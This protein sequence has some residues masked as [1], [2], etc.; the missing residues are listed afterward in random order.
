M[1]KLLRN[2]LL[3]SVGFASP[4]ALCTAAHAAAPSEMLFILDGSGSMWGQVDGVT[5]IDTAKTTLGSLLDNVPAGARLGLITY[6]NRDEKSCQDITYANPIGSDPA[7]IKATV[8]QLT[9]LGKTPIDEAINLAFKK[10]DE[11]P[12]DIKRS[13]VLVSDGIETCNGNPC[14]TASLA[15]YHGVDL[16]IHVVGF[17]VDAEARKQLECIADAAGGQYFNAADTKGFQQAMAS[18]VQVTQAEPEPAPAP[19]APFFQD[20]FDGEALSDAWT[21]LNEDPDGYI[22]EDGS[23]LMASS[24]V[25]GFGSGEPTNLVTFNG[26]MPKG[27]WDM[28]M[29]VKF[30]GQTGRDSI[31]FGLYTD[32]QNYLG[33][34][35]TYRHPYCP[36][37][38]LQLVK[39]AKGV[40]A[41]FGART[42]GMCHTGSTGDTEAVVAS[43]AEDGMILTLSKRGRAYHATATLSG[44][45]GD[46]GSARSVS[47][48]ALTSLRLPGKPAFMLGKWENAN[49][50]ILSYID[51]IVITPVE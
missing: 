46:A 35:Y 25:Q 28:T 23:L 19:T 18:V 7:A 6:G 37:T 24:Q 29:H 3:A 31:W 45:V 9:P 5:K 4:I 21:V 38:V 50:E 22:V 2:A 26:D 39:M 14:D 33:I 17:D 42:S 8:E 20:D 11:N 10:L 43:Q 49:G 27:D 30:D 32:P 36:E 13:I 48:D 1:N 12:T 34:Q 15:K 16:K 44:I 47:T 41:H 40:E 51:K